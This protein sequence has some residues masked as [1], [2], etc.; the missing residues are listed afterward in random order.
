MKK[1]VVYFAWWD[2]LLSEWYKVCYVAETGNIKRAKTMIVNKLKEAKAQDCL[3]RAGEDFQIIPLLSS[4][5]PNLSFEHYSDD[6]RLDYYPPE[7]SLW[8]DACSP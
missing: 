1:I 8:I 6:L 5:S 2:T 7:I 4:I 3:P